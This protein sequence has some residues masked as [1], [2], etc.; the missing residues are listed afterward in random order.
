MAG[1]SAVLGIEDVRSRDAPFDGN[2]DRDE[3]VGA[4]LINLCLPSARMLDLESGTLDTTS[5]PRCFTLR[6]ESV[7][8]CAI[9]AESIRVRVDLRVTG[10]RPLVLASTSSLTV[11]AIIDVSSSVSAAGASSGAGANPAFCEAGTL[12][13]PSG[14]GAGGS[15][16]GSGARGGGTQGATGS[17][18]GAPASS[19]SIR[20]GCGGTPGRGGPAVMAGPGGGAIYLIAKDRITINRS[21]N[22]SG[23][24]GMGGTADFRGGNG[25]GAGGLIG[26]DAPL[27]VGNGSVFANGGGG[28]GG[29]NNSTFGSPG[30]VSTSTFSRAFGGSAPSLAG[31]GGHGSVEDELDG[32]PGSGTTDSANGGGGGGGGAGVIYVRGDFRFTG[33]TSP[34][35]RTQ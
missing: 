20:G 23:G 19:L 1:C 17:Q 4:G 24:N 10:T 18:P 3:C 5:D 16:G 2:G 12:P 22:A 26:L 15:F 7:E 9:V 34:E 6:S 28:G 13:S 21:I 8:L 29:A 11:D 30:T 31:S 27:I 32:T 14:G 33:Q 25:A 35:E